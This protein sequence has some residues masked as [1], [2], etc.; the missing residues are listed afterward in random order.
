MQLF[1]LIIEETK[2][3]GFLPVL[4]MLYVSWECPKSEAFTR[5]KYRLVKPAALQG[6]VFGAD[7]FGCIDE[8]CGA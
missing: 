5:V 1:R 6:E 2:I 8:K 4:Q 7:A 3:W